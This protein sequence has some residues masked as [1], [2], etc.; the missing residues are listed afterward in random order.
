MNKTLVIFRKSKD[1]VTALFPLEPGDMS[2]ATMTCYAHVGQHGVADML[3]P[4]QTKLAKPSEYRSLA[5][6]LRKIGYKLQIGKRIPR[7]ALEVRRNKLAA[8]Q[9]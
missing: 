6:E 1:E 7:N 9:K 5:K 3:W 4:R 8:M 2:P